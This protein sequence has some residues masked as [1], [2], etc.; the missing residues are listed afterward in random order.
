MKHM[1]SFHSLW[2]K[3]S[4]QAIYGISALLKKKVSYENKSE[5]ITYTKQINIK[6]VLSFVEW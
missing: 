5:I 3:P 2:K 1:L 6:T 4:F